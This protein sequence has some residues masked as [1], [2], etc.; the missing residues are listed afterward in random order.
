MHE[1]RRNCITSLR[2]HLNVTRG[3]TVCKYDIYVYNNTCAFGFQGK[4]RV[5][6][7]Y[8]QLTAYMIAQGMQ[9]I[10]LF[11]L[12]FILGEFLHQ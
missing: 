2:L 11:A 9:D 7:V 3:V 8:S 4:S 1:E 5:K 12:A 6:E 10:E